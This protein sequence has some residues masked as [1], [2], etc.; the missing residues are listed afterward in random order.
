MGAGGIFLYPLAPSQSLLPCPHGLG[1]IV[2][3]PTSKTAGKMAFQGS[4][5]G[6]IQPPKPVKT[7]T[8]EG[9]LQIRSKGLT[10]VHFSSV[11]SEVFSPSLTPR[12]EVNHMDSCSIDNK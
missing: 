5:L 11:F 2:N 7:L 8:I 12:Q 3:T 1:L 4:T 9:T 6:Q 10:Q